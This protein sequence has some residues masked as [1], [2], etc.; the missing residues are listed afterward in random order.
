MWQYSRVAGVT[1]TST[2]PWPQ[3]TV[4]RDSPAAKIASVVRTGA[5]LWLPGTRQ[6]EGGNRDGRDRPFT[7][8]VF[9]AVIAEPAYLFT[10]L[11]V[12]DEGY[13][14]E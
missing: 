8:G 7:S 4:V 5:T 11:T 2:R 6:A 1:F 9:Q 12:T 14:R 3:V 13:C 10:T